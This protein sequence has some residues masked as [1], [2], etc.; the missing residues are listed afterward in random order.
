MIYSNDIVWHGY[1]VG[2]K[3]LFIS[4]IYGLECSK[5]EIFLFGL[6]PNEVESINTLQLDLDQAKHVNFSG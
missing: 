5:M 6:W 3:N 4:M 1:L 2:I